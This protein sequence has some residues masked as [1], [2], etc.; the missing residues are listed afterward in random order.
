MQQQTS[1]LQQNNTTLPLS[2]REVFTSSIPLKAILKSF[3]WSR[4]STLWNVCLNNDELKESPITMWPLK[5]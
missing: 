3:F 2:S 4:A 1:L 5:I